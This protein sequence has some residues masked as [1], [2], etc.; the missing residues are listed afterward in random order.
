MDVLEL[1]NYCLSLSDDIE[2]KFPFG[3]FHGAEDILVFYTCGHMFCYFDINNCELVNVKCQSERIESLKDEHECLKKPFNMS[4]R[5]WLGIN[6][7]LADDSLIKELVK[8]SFEIVAKKY[9]K[10]P[11]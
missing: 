4:P 10:H 5:H 2:E 8:N 1:R 3:K 6:M 9:R 11:K 7:E